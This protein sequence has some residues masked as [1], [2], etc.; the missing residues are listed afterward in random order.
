MKKEPQRRDSHKKW[1]AKLEAS[2]LINQGL[3][4]EDII[5]K[6]S[7]DYEY[8]EA[9]AQTIYYAAQR[10]ANKAISDY[11][12]EAAKVNVQRLI[13]IIDA[14]FA[15]KKYGDSLKAID[16]LNKMGGLYAPEEHNINTN[17]EPIKISFE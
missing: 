14:A 12:N 4:R 2:T 7:E 1:R 11:I 13:S 9:T 10:N 6:L 15:E 5:A 17:A 3:S 16:T 8:S